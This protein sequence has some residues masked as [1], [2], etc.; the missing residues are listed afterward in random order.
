[1]KQHKLLQDVSTKWNSVYLM[2][3]RLVE[4][5]QAVSAVLLEAANARHLLPSAADITH[6][7]AI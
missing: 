2:M 5:Q 3:E 4:Q 1:M 6:M 7:E